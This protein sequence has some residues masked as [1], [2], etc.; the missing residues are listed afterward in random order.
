M[1]DNQ[2]IP[3]GERLPEDDDPVLV[4]WRG[5]MVGIAWFTKKGKWRDIEGKFPETVTHWMPMPLPPEAQP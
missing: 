2:W 5:Y 3:V 1:T 4:S